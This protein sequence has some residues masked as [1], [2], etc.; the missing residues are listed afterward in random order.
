MSD[1]PA[2]PAPLQEMFARWGP[3]YRWYVT[4]TAMMGTISTV[5][6]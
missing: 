2:S 5:L 6:S 3:N 1:A 4:V